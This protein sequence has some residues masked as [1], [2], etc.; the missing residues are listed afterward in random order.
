MLQHPS[1]S[2]TNAYRVNGIICVELVTGSSS[3]T[4][5][6]RFFNPSLSHVHNLHPSHAFLVLPDKPSSLGDSEITLS[7]PSGEQCQ[8]SLSPPLSLKSLLP[9]ISHGSPRSEVHE[10]CLYLLASYFTHSSIIAAAL[11]L[12]EHVFTA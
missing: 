7:D 10:V 8:P 1:K 2:C 12:L 6:S 4:P 11:K 9:L 3:S 5:H